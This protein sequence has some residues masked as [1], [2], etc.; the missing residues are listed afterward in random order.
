[1]VFPARGRRYGQVP[2]AL[3]GPSGRDMATSARDGSDGS[4][5]RSPVSVK[6]A[7]AYRRRAGALFSVTHRCKVAAPGCPLAHRPTR[8]GPPGVV[9]SALPGWQILK[10]PPFG[11]AQCAF[12]HFA[13]TGAGLY[14]DSG[15]EARSAE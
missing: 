3:M 4:G 8:P 1:M 10:L 6:P 7:R 14:H 2:G 13:T 12:R 5:W 9:A 11:T 15:L